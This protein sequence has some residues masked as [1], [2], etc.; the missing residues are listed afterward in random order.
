MPSVIHYHCHRGNN[1]NA[2]LYK[3]AFTFVVNIAAVLLVFWVGWGPIPHSF[4][5]V[6]TG[7]TISFKKAITLT[8]GYLP[9]TN[10]MTFQVPIQDG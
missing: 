8:T 1:V 9:L 10:Q 3:S 5:H 2:D 4:V 7:K 6:N